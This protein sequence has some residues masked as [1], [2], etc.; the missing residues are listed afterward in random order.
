MTAK[1]WESTYNTNSCSQPVF[2]PNNIFYGHLQI[3]CNYGLLLICTLETL[4]YFITQ[5]LRLYTKLNRRLK[6]SLEMFLVTCYAFSSEERCNLLMYLTRW[7]HIDNFLFGW[8][9]WRD[10]VTTCSI[11]IGFMFS[12][13]LISWIKLFV[14]RQLTKC[15]N[16]NC[17]LK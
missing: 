14:R 15:I 10:Y 3:Q 1:S 8:S 7:F 4:A 5:L 9:L 16:F 17:S 13:A 12:N 11:I 2:F 6:N